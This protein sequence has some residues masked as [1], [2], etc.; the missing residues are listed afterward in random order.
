MPDFAGAT[1]GIQTF[2][3]FLV[4]GLKDAFPDAKITVFAK[5]DRCVPPPDETKVA[6][7]HATGTWSVRQRTAAFTWALVTNTVRRRPNMIIIAH[8]NFVLVAYLLQKFLG[9]PYM[10]IGHGVEVWKKPNDRVKAAL[11]NAAKLMAVSS[12][13]RARMSEVLGLSIDRIGLLPNT[14]DPSDFKI[15]PKP[16]FLLIPKGSVWTRMGAAL[17]N[18]VVVVAQFVR[19]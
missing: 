9:I 16:R 3:Y 10:A 18:R 13:T 1:G 17:V 5:N 19:S 12:F 6:R 14:F 2:S 7:F 11:R 4:H 8:I 15:R